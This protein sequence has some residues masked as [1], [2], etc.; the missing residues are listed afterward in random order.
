MSGLSTPVSRIRYN[1]RFIDHH[2]FTRSEIRRLYDQAFEAKLDMIV[3]TEKDAVRLFRDIKPKLPVYFLRLEIDILSGEE[4]F[5]AA[6]A[7]ICLP[8]NK[9][10]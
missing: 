9:S 3:T 2:R 5:E 7:R 4:D 8:K 10:V 6:A 1:R